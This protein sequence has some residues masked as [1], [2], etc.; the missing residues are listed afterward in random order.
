MHNNIET[1]TGAKARPLVQ[2]RKNP[3]FRLRSKSQ[4]KPNKKVTKSKS[5]ALSEAL[6]QRFEKFDLINSLEQAS[7]GIIMRQIARGDIDMAIDDLL[8]VLSGISVRSLVN[9]PNKDEVHWLLMYRNLLM[10]VKI[11]FGII[12][13]SIRFRSYLEC[14][15]SKND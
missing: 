2:P 3:G 15:V 14:Y 7:A 10:R 4:R 8:R 5:K 6:C 9:F 1:F 13:G 12:T 11:T